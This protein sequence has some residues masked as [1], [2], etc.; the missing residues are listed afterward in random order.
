M[1]TIRSGRPGWLTT[2]AIALFALGCEPGEVVP[3]DAAIDAGTSSRDAGGGSGERDGGDAPLDASTSGCVDDPDCDDGDP[4]TDDF[5]FDGRC[6]WFECTSARPEACDDL[7]PSTDDVCVSTETG[8]MCSHG[9]VGAGCVE[10][11]DCADHLDCTT[12]RC[13][14]EGVCRYDW[15][16]DCGVHRD[17]MPPCPAGAAVGD[18]CCDDF[19]P[20][21]VSSC[22]SRTSPAGCPL[23]L[24]CG[25][26]ARGYIPVYPAG[27]ACTNPCPTVPVDG[28]ACAFTGMCNYAMDTWGVTVQSELLL[29]YVPGPFCEC[30]DG[31]LRCRAMTVCPLAPPTPGS[32]VVAAAGEPMAIACP[33][34]DRECRAVP[35]ASGA[36]VWDCDSGVDCPA[37]APTTGE[38][39]IRRLSPCDYYRWNGSLPADT[40]TGSCTCAV[41]TWACTPSTSAGCPASQPMHGAPCG[42]LGEPPPDGLGSCLYYDADWN[43]TTCRCDMPVPGLAPLWTC[44]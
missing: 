4:T 16:G 15:S 32:P 11:A 8:S 1:R 26:G 9:R 5:C 27:G 38:S 28:A 34:I 3:D 10:A 21:C 37:A 33:Y 41:D 43:Q 12:D 20:I 13:S 18:I 39:C 44:S 36:L 24:R 23:E 22:V 19:T 40:Y 7:D 17:P 14:P 6:L 29:E 42:D 31:T 2:L 30:R 35:D 25:L